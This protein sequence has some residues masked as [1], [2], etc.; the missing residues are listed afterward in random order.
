MSTQTHPA[1]SSATELNHLISRAGVHRNLHAAELVEQSLR[2]GEG[3]HLASNG[4]LVGITGKRTGRS[5]KDKFTVKDQRTA[6]KIYW[7]DINQPISPEKFDALYRRVLDYLKT[8][9]LFVQDLF[10]GADP[11]YRLPIRIINELAWHNLFVRELF[12]RPNEQELQSHEPEFTVI[13][14]PS[15]MADP[16]RDGIKSEA[17]ILVNFT[18]GIILI[19]GTLYA[20]EMKKCVFGVMNFLLPERDVLPMHCSANIGSD[21]ATALF[22][23]LSGTGKT[24]L[25]ANPERGLIG[26][27]EH[28]WSPNGVFNFEGGCYAKCI[29]LSKEKEPQIYNAIRFGC[30]LE[31]VVLQPVTAEP[32]YDNDSLTEN[33]RAAYPVDFIEHAVIPGVG[34][35][36]KNIILLTADAF[37]VLPPIARL[38]PEQAMYHFLS[39]YTAKIAGTEAGLGKEP[40][41]TFSTGF[42]APFLPLAPKIYAEML[43][44]RLREHD[45]QCW[46]V[47][48]GWSGGRYGVGKRM[49]LPYTRAMV[50]AVVDGLLVKSEFVTESAFGLQIPRSCPDV[51][52]ELLNP[53]NAWKD[54][55]A[56]DKTAIELAERFAKNFEKFDVPELI[57][58]AGPAPVAN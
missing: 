2:R 22:F 46:L 40:Q 49:S 13:S 7:G 47:N 20:G 38:T 4:A 50:R 1:S 3:T 48:T 19:G 9:E 15:F 35:H 56:Y 8:R 23:G 17:F 43:G 57:R 36:P 39:G 28:G 29:H 58:E 54:K 42:G 6:N 33:T 44:R 10:A 25:S 26:D 51:P 27:D 41:A 11:K 30:V 16:Q 14:A 31:N 32:D 55:A 53:R 37:G 5:P 21:G 18:E 24:T 45:A 52:G 12:V 34:G